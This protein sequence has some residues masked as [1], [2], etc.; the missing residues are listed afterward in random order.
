MSCLQP[1]LSIGA[2][3]MKQLS[4]S[5]VMTVNFFINFAKFCENC[6]RQAL[7]LINSPI[8]KISQIQVQA[9]NIKKSTLSQTQSSNAFISSWFLSQRIPMFVNSIPMYFVQF[10][11]RF[12]PLFYCFIFYYIYL[13]C[14]PKL[15]C[16]D[17]NKKIGCYFI[18][19]IGFHICMK[20]L[21]YLL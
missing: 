11:D 5:H 3:V 20:L 18:Y 12:I 19:D 2:L 8:D 17:K 13:N 10:F 16:Y 9:Q 21:I 1:I 14:H 7:K 4:Y 6:C 15:R